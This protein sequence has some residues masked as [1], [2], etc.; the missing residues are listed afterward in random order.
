MKGL[1]TYRRCEVEDRS[2]I[3]L[4][5]ERSEAAITETQIKYGKYCHYIAYN[6]LNS[7]ED[8]EECVNDTYEKAWNS[9]PPARPERLSAFLGRI[10]RN[11]ALN[12]LVHAGAKKRYAGIEMILDEVEEFIPDTG[13]NEDVTDTIL[14]KDVLNRFLRSLP[15]QTRIIFVRRYWYMGSVKE[16]SKELGLTESNVKVIL[17]RTRQKLKD[18]LEKEGVTI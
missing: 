5:F 13:E 1:L 16:I 2:I 17:L 15:G 14:L 11:I 9:I 6:I 7:K 18:T 4:Y 10:T 12:R 3:D 8:A